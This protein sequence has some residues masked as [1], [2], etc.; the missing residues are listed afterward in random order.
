MAGCAQMAVGVLALAWSALAQRLSHGSSGRVQPV[1]DTLGASKDGYTTYQVTADFSPVEALDVYAVFGEASRSCDRDEGSNCH[2]LRLPPAFQVPTPFGVNTGPT[3][4]AFF[5]ISPD[6]EF[7]SFITLGV[8]GPALIQG[9]MSSVGIHFDSWS[10]QQGIDTADGAVFFMDP[11]SLALPSLFAS[12]PSLA[13]VS[14]RL[15]DSVM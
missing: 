3:N 11:G 12:S 6:A 14:I 10:E 1:V 15:L 5:G 8:D 2:N 4:P 13:H 9:A 7:D